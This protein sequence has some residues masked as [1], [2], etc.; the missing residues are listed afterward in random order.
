MDRCSQAWLRHQ[1]RVVRDGFKGGDDPATGQ[2]GRVRFPEILGQTLDRIGNEFRRS[3]E[4]FLISTSVM[5]SP[6]L[7]P[8]EFRANDRY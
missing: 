1:H 8:A 5:P 7:S 3:V 2:D 6:S 4:A